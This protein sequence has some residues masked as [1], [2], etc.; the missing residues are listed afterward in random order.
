MLITVQNAQSTC[1]C[2]ATYEVSHI[3]GHMES[4][5]SWNIT[6]QV[7]TQ[8]AVLRVKHEGHHVGLAQF[9]MDGLGSI[10]E[11]NVLKSIGYG[12]GL[13]LLFQ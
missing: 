2:S 5:V 6:A 8:K 1:C 7:P 3:G 13:I 9:F 4:E 10:G 11:K 12:N